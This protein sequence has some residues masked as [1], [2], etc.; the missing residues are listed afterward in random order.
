MTAALRRWLPRVVVGVVPPLLLAVSIAR[1]ILNHLFARAPYLYDSGLLSGLVYRNGLLLPTPK[2]A[3]NYA[4]YFWEI[5]VSPWTALLSLAS[6]VV[7]VGR[8]EWFA[9]AQGLSYAPLGL[10]V[11]V[12][13]SRLDPDT[14]LRRLPITFAAAV[15]F[16]FNG[17]VLWMV[18]YPHFEVALFG[19]ACLTLAAFVSGRT[20]LAWICLALTVSVRQ[21]GGFV[22]ATALLPLLLLGWRGVA[23]AMPRRRLV[24]AF[25]IA[26]AASVAAMVF[27]RLAFHAVARVTSAYLGDPPYAHLTADLLISR[28]RHFLAMD[29]LIYYPFLAT[30]LIAA[31]RRDAGY[32]LGWVGALPWFLWDFTAVEEVKATFFA[33]GA[34]PFLIG[35]VW[36]YLY[37]AYIA[38]RRLPAAALELTFATVCISSTLGVYRGA[39]SIA[40]TVHDMVSSQRRDRAAVHAFVD[41]IHDHHAL[42][43]RLRAD[44]AVTTLAM[45]TLALD[46]TWTPGMTGV[47]TLAFHRESAGGG[48]AMIPELLANQLDVCAHVRR[49]GIFACTHDRLPPEAL[50]G[51]PVDIVPSSLIFADPVN[52]RVNYVDVNERGIVFRGGPVIA[53]WLGTLPAGTYEWTIAL[54][55]DAPAGPELARIEIVQADSIIAVA[56]ATGDART[57]SLHF[58]ADGSSHPIGYHIGAHEATITAAKLRRLP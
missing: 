8:L 2:I 51:V 20:R 16:A 19:F 10:V 28:A 46:E 36:V 12:V 52:A 17:M 39:P 18:G 57:L 58:A 14:R 27:Q 43:G 34:G 30:C 5:Y 26:V 6:Y 23:L 44:Y 15:A 40:L 24:L 48:L 47:D 31:L 22:V 45:E 53:G 25:A 56:A 7:P 54:A 37:G 42:F 35:L 50:A 33:Y 49:T 1:Y 3:C 13:A 38:R 4:D 11:Y 55:T 21:D 29:Q 32:L 9:I 41:A